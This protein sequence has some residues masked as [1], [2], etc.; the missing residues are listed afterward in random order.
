MIKLFKKK[1][2]R[3]SMVVIVLIILVG[4]IVITVA[5]KANEA[6]V[7]STKKNVASAG[8]NN[9]NKSSQSNNEANNVEKNDTAKSAENNSDNATNANTAANT[10]HDT[11]PANA[12]SSAGS[13]ST[14]S[15]EQPKQVPLKPEQHLEVQHSQP[16]VPAKPVQQPIPASPQKYVSKTLGFS[17][18]FPASWQG[19]YNV[20]ENN[21]ELIVY[22]KPVNHPVGA[23]V[24]RLFEIVK[25]TPDV[26]EAV[27]DTISGAKRDFATKGVTFVI[28]GPTDVAFPPDNPEYSTYKQLSSERSSVI[29]TIE[30]IN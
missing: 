12:N 20:V 26:N 1:L 24:G 25:K 27:L 10:A 2:I 21:N 7:N 30:S 28:G 4:T 3:W 6:S 9:D 15:P 19:K 13:Q 8:E 5:K 18:T 14:T 23:G 11:A 22:F 29:N 17:L 16:A